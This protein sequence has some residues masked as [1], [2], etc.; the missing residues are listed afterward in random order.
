MNPD[1]QRVHVRKGYEASS[2]N[3]SA[4]EVA[5]RIG[6]TDA[7][8]ASLPAGA[9]LGFGCAN[10]C[11][12]ADLRPGEW[13]VDLG[14]GAG[15][16]VF[17]GARAVGSTGRAIGVDMTRRMLER[18]RAAAAHFDCGN[19][20]FRHGAIESLPVADQSVDVV[21][22][23]GVINLS[24]E[25]ARV[26]AEALRVL[27]PS[28]RLVVADLAYR[29]EIDPSAAKVAQ[30]YLGTLLEPSDYPLAIQR[31][32][33]EDVVVRA[34]LEYGDGVLRHV[35]RFNDSAR[36]DGVSP[37]TLDAFLHGLVAVIVCA[38]RP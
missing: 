22:S 37:A 1:E 15:I 5:A 3:E 24:P 2:P 27:K 35:T 21:I 34:E 17:I 20:E 38:S 26:F 7:Q 36:E 14:S 10:P 31:A 13:L 33:F 25:R 16:D 4:A 6:Y 11:A 23:N 8:I 28:G 12:Y 32:G 9:N 18:A 29:G 30:R 19:V